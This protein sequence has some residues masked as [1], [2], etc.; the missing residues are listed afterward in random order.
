MG[1]LEDFDWACCSFLERN[2]VED[3]Y[4]RLRDRMDLCWDSR[5]VLAC[6]GYRHEHALSLEFLCSLEIAADF[7]KVWISAHG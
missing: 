1:L 3:T 7:G 5:D 2:Y 4:P 6:S